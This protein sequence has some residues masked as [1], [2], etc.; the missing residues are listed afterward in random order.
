MLTAG[1]TAAVLAIE[2]LEV[3]ELAQDEFAV[4]VTLPPVL[5]G[6]A[7]MLVPVVV[8]LQPEGNVQV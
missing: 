8:P 7:W 6:K 5:P 3:G 1:V 4:T 2:R